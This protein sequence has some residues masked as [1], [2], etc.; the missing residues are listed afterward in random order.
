LTPFFDCA[1]LQKIIKINNKNGLLRNSFISCATDMINKNIFIIIFCLSCINTAFGQSNSYPKSIVDRSLTLPEN[2]WEISPFL[3]KGR[4]YDIIMPVIFMNYGLTDKV[5]L[6]PIGI[7]YLVFNSK[8]SELSLSSDFGFWYSTSGGFGSKVRV[9]T[10]NLFRFKTNLALK[11]EFSFTYINNSGDEGLENISVSLNPILKVND[12]FDSMLKIIFV[13][14]YSYY[15]DI[16]LDS[17]VKKRIT[18]NNIKFE[19]GG[20]YHLLGDVD[21][22]S[23]LILN[24][25]NSNKDYIIGANWRF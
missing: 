7:S 19:L 8:Q 9:A 17:A 2:K 10:T 4:D 23:F 3:Y 5:Q 25:S 22:F 14:S 24:D 16:S 18:E 13:Q 11:S 1:S 15:E 20:W 21:L 6:R 12:D